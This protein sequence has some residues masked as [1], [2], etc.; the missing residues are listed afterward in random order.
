M[1]AYQ[2]ATMFINTA[3]SKCLFSHFISLLFN[4]ATA[5][6]APSQHNNQCTVYSAD[7]LQN[8]RNLME[9][10]FLYMTG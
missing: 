2:L 9:V 8:D 5:V 6:T 1:K 7:L 10:T 4:I 3:Y